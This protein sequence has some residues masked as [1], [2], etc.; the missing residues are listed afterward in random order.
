MWYTYVYNISSAYCDSFW[1][2]LSQNDEKILYTHVYHIVGYLGNCED[3]HEITD[4]VNEM[5]SVC[6]PLVDI[7]NTTWLDSSGLN[8]N[9]G[10][11]CVR[12]YYLFEKFRIVGVHGWFLS[13]SIVAVDNSCTIWIGDQTRHHP[14][15]LRLLYESNQKA[16][17]L[18]RPFAYGLAENDSSTQESCQ[19]YRTA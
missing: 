18:W 3:L 1:R 10:L 16:F 19:R 8:L 9:C 15:V 5:L 12:I 17:R 11:N 13:T 7:L 4:L 14:E 6:A 2:K